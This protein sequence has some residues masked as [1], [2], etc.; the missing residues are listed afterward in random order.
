[1]HIGQDLFTYHVTLFIAKIS[2]DEGKLTSVENT[3]Y[4]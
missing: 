4:K 1:M 2:P 3:T